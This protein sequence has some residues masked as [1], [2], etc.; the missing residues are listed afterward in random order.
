MPEPTDG[1][2][3]EASARLLIT[4]SNPRDVGNRQIFVSLDGSAL[5]DLLFKEQIERP[6]TPGHHRLRVHNTL[7]W[8]T[9]EFEAQ[10]GE[11]VHFETTN[12]ASRGFVSLVLIL[13][14]APLFLSVE[15]VGVRGDAPMVK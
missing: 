7:F 3:V 11:T 12:Y 9:L 14:V 1:V 2:S 4:R 6:I 10:P 15:R 8:K 13:G 5:G